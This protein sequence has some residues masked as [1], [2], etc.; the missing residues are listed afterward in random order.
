MLS[1]GWK[2]SYY[3]TCPY[4]VCVYIYMRLSV[5][6]CRLLLSCACCPAQISS[7]VD[8][9]HNLYGG[10]NGISK[11][12]AAPRGLGLTKVPNIPLKQVAN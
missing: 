2:T 7:S 4:V 3:C 6:M 10:L 12:D 11:E 8:A 5:Y 9:S 1:V